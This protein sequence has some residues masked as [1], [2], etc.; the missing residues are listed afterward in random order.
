MWPQTEF[1]TLYKG[2]EG[3]EVLRRIFW[4]TFEDLGRPQIIFHLYCSTVWIDWL[5]TLP[6]SQIRVPGS[7]DKSFNRENKLLTVVIEVRSPEYTE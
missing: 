6:L 7:I 3:I 4:T 1:F 5:D 2:V